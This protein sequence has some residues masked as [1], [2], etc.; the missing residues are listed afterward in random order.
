MTNNPLVQRD[1]IRL[2][3]LGMVDGNGHP[4]SWS[5]IINGFDAEAMKQCPYS[6]IPTY[7]SREP[8]EALGI[9][10]AKVTHIWTDDPKDA[11]KVARASL[12]PHVV[13]KPEDVLGEV[14]AVIVATDIGS[15]HVERCR[16][17]V[18]AGIPVFI[19][20][21]LV[22][23]ETDLQTF[24]R[25]VADGK[26]ILS[27]SSMRFCKEYLPYR[28]STRNMG[29]LRFATMTTMKTWERYGVHALEGVYPIVGPGFVS[30]RNTGDRER[31]IVHLKHASGVDV[32]VAAVSDMYGAFG[33]L[34]LC[35]TQGH[36]F[37]KSN[38]T[39]YSFKAQLVAF[40]DYLRTGERPFPFAETEE[41]MKLVIAGIRSREE[42]GR[43]VALDEI[44][45]R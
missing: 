42:G 28:L 18:E 32:V 15:E 5:A 27:T 36:A 19:D 20:K 37:V 10:G 29:E 4:Y 23:N 43:E 12:I 14:D 45:S 34:Q 22:D 13:S 7:L 1:T 16:P 24:C 35:G 2:A 31:N 6:A 17:F 33:L 41:L 25:W 38:D 3:M 40:V 9:A 21:P 8:K 26:A 44:R 30:V 39:F 11:D